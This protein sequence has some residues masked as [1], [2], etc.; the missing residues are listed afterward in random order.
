MCGI[1]GIF[2]LDGRDVDPAVLTRMTDVMVHRGPDAG[3]I[4]L[5]GAVGFGHRRLAIRDLTAAGR[6]PMS[7]PSGRITVTYNGE[8]YNEAELRTELEH[9]FGFVSRSHCDTE[10][11]PAGYLAWGEKLFSRIEGIFAMGLWDRAARRLI[12]A[13]DPVGTK[14]IFFS[15]IGG[16]VRFASEIKGLLADPQHPRALDSEGLHRFLAMGYV[17]PAATTMRHIRQVEP[18]SI[19]VYDREGEASR[20]FWQPHRKQGFRRLDEAV[21]CFLPLFEQVV[22]DQLISDVPVGI[23][24]SGGIDSSLIAYS[25]AKR[26]KFP[27]VTASFAE[28]SHDETAIAA[29]VAQETSMPHRIVPVSEDPHPEDTLAR[30]VHHFDGQVADESAGPLLLLT[31]ELRRNSTVALSGDGADEFFGGYPTYRASRLAGGPGAAIPAGLAGAVGKLL[32]A[33]LGANEKRLPATALLARFLL[34]IAAGGRH[35]H[36]EWRRYIPDFMLPSLYGPGLRALVDVSPMA[37][38]RAAIDRAD[39]PT[40]LDRCLISDQTYH[41]PSGLLMKTD[42]MSMANS[43][44]IRVPFLDRR[45]MEFSGSCS[46]DLVVPARGPTKPVLRNAL[47][48]KGASERIWNAPKRGFNN[49]LA[50][51]L[52]GPMRQLCDNVFVRS[53]GI[54]EPYLQPDA[55]RDLWQSHASRTTNHAYALWPLLTLALWRSELAG[56]DLFVRRD[57]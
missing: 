54:F 26:G 45:I 19:V 37:G 3:E 49:P 12:L 56:D 34:G 22:N 41:L 36:A 28:Q 20:R 31:R 38:Y 6:Q 32:Y 9:D 53:R 27:L 23:L 48:R 15:A 40:M 46:L 51:L 50:G 16:V 52:R 5:G 29:L 57:R 43:V 42:A 17:G 55:V 2:N 14:P 18:G 4:W 13:R 25:V 44:E 7:D 1:A 47:R 24:Q 35:A 21:E 10:I 33:A 8:I 39:G 30:V 11:L